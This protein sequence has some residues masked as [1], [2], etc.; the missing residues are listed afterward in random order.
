[1]NSG[2]LLLAQSATSETAKAVAETTSEPFLTYFH[3]IIGGMAGLTA[4]GLTIWFLIRPEKGGGKHPKRLP[5]R[6][7]PANGHDSEV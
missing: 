1:M 3:L 7:Q 2:L 5:L 6:E 4:V